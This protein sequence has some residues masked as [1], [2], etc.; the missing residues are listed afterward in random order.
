VGTEK[1]RKWGKGKR[2]GE[3]EERGRKTDRQTDRD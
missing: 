3:R 1:V 2:V